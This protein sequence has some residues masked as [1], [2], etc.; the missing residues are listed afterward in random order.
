MTGISI[1]MPAYNV[2]KYLYD[3]IESI[4]K[5]T[6][7]DVE[8]VCVD[9]GSTDDTLEILKQMKKDYDKIKIVHQ[10]NAGPGIA[11]NTGIENSNGDYIAFLDADDIFLDETALEKMYRDAKKYDADMVAANL[12][13]INPD[14]TLD[15]YYDFINSK[16]NYFYKE[17]LY[18][19]ED[20]GIPFAFYKNIYK[21]SFI[22]KHNITFPDMRAGEDPIFMVNV[23]VN[24]DKFPALPIDL[25]G[26][27]H[28]LGGGV[29]EKINTYERKYDYIKHFKDS[30]DILK[31]DNEK[32]ILQGYK[33][34][35]LN[36]IIY[37]DNMQDEDIQK[38]LEEL[39][40]NYED[41]FDKG[42]YGYFVMEYMLNKD[43]GMDSSGQDE[44]LM[45]KKCLFEES[46]IENNF[47]DLNY[48]R[49]YSKYKTEN[50]SNN[51]SKLEKTSFD[52][53]NKIKTLTSLEMESVKDE[54]KSL[55]S[56]L[57]HEI[58]DKNAEFLRKY[59]ECRIDI[60]NNGNEDNT[61]EL[62]DCDDDLVHVSQPGWLK[63]EKG[64]GK[65]LTSI[66]GNINFSFKCVND[67]TLIIDFKGI[68]YKDKNMVRI[69]LYIDY[70]EIIVDG[71]RL[72]TDS[73]VSWHDNPFLYKKEVSD[74]QI[75]RV[76]AQWQPLTYNSDLRLIT[77]DEKLSDIF[78]QGRID[79]KNQGNKN[80]S[81][82]FLD[83]ASNY[84]ITQPKW[85]KD[86]DGVGS[87]ISSNSG[88]LDLSFKC[89]GDGDLVV[90]FR[91]IDF[92]D[93]LRNRIPLFVDYYNIVIDDEVILNHSRISWH[94]NSFDYTKKVKDGQTVNMHVEWSPLINY[95]TQRN[96]SYHGLHLGDATT[97]EIKRLT[98]EKNALSKENQELKEFKESLLNSN[99]WKLT[100]PLRSIRNFRK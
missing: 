49:D 6:F 67:G 89:I 56:I 90:N 21:R 59:T 69:P 79:I 96:L 55:N 97:I 60:K 31:K 66:N 98:A 68:D 58:Y 1:V 87:I 92:R 73:R 10:E 43:S 95:D 26:Y 75:V 85:F 5:Q 23:L 35:F 12:R 44:F 13:R 41:Y 100:K 53:L 30:F 15:E 14:Y 65:V 8:I 64:I 27:N 7:K 38:I 50:Y 88:V 93:S 42:D 84:S 22:N 77:T 80:N 62:E 36:Y 82:E 4:K 40:E 76:S 71:K 47:I 39:F 74:G 72:I 20:Y 94:D 70:T 3:S 63:N 17:G 28:S 9:D 34:E 99:S 52:E 33:H 54:V 61:I 81:L 86:S 91:G 19:S 83:S 37:S 25:Y 29:N 18:E 78:N 11:R 2:S 51:T 32:R 16:F 45:I 48:L 24:L 57:N 46:C